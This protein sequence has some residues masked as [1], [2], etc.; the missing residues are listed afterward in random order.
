MVPLSLKLTSGPTS[1]GC[2]SAIRPGSAEARAARTRHRAVSRT[3]GPL[4]YARFGGGLRT[5]AHS[6]SAR[7]VIIRERTE[8]SALLRL[9]VPTMVIRNESDLVCKSRTNHARPLGSLSACT[10][11]SIHL[12]DF[13]VRGYATRNYQGIERSFSCPQTSGFLY[14]IFISFGI[15]LPHRPSPRHSLPRRNLRKTH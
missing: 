9:I 13:P 5:V 10:G 7:L 4:S 11:Y 15:R 6:G 8:S 14:F 2:V 12:Q 3:T 1:S